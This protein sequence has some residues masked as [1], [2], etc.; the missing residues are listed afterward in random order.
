MFPAYSYTNFPGL[1]GNLIEVQRIHD[2][3]WINTSLG[4]YYFSQDTSY[5]SRVYIEKVNT[6]NSKPVSAKMKPNSQPQEKELEKG[7]NEESDE[8]ETSKKKKRKRKAF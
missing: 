5:R 1:E 2:D 8:E 6:K 3:L 7:Q 4:V